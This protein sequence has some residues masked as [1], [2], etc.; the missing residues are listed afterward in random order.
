ARAARAQRLARA[1]RRPR[2][3]R[4]GPATRAQATRARASTPERAAAP[5][6][7]AR[8]ARAA[9]SPRRSGPT[10][11]RRPSAEGSPAAARRAAGGAWAARARMVPPASDPTTWG[12]VFWTSPRSAWTPQT[13]PPPA[14]ID[15]GPY[16]ATI[17]GSH[18]VLTGSPDASIGVAMRKDYAAD[19]TRG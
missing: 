14:A 15:N 5:A 17:S 6:P 10:A 9:S 19:P 11:T 4:P 16:A 18:L 3:A 12:S 1:G 13:W 8:A 2:A 7:A